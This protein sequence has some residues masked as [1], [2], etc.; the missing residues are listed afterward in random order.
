M[1]EQLSDDFTLTQLDQELDDPFGL[2][3]EHVDEF[4]DRMSYLHRAFGRIREMAEIKASAMIERHGP[5]S[6][7]DGSGYR[8]P[9]RRALLAFLKSMQYMSLSNALAH[10][11]PCVDRP[12][13][14]R[15][16]VGF[17]DGSRIRMRTCLDRIVHDSMLCARNSRSYF[18]A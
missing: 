17:H 7:K 5:R 10:R 3:E 12:D 8:P 18:R 13:K 2:T 9:S 14:G 11:T 16:T 1:A 15:A 6:D 4:C